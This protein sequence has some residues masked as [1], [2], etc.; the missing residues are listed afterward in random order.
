MHT[1][2][3]G[4]RLCVT[5]CPLQDCI[6]SGRE[7]S[8]REVFLK[9]KDGE[10]LAVYVKTAVFDIEGR[11]Y[12]VE[13]FG[14]LES[15]AGKE[16]AGRIQE[17]S[18]SAVS[19]PL[20][21]LFNRRYLDAAL[22]QQFAMFRR[23]GRRYGV[24]Q[25]DI[26]TL[27]TINDRLGHATGD[28]AIR[29]VAGILASN[30][31][32][33]DIAARFGG[34]EFVIICGLATEDDLAVYGRRLVR[35]V[36]DSRFAPAEDSGLR[37]TVSAGGSLVAVERRRRAGGAGTRRRRHV[38]GQ[39]PRPRRVRGDRRRRRAVTSGG[40]VLRRNPV[41]GKLTIVAPARASRPADASGRDVAAPPC[42][43]CAGN[44][45]LTPPEVDA[46]RPARRRA[47]RPRLDRARGPQQ[48]PRAG[49]PARGDRARARAR[50]GARG[51]S[52]RRTRRG[53]RHVAA[54][55]RRAARG[56]GRGRD[57]DRQPGGRLRGLAGAPARAAV[58]DA[59]GATAAARGAPRGRAVPQ[60]LRHLR[61]LRPARASR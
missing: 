31:R 53:R 61:G 8:I 44:E 28:E 45:A 12:G 6:D 27:K 7:H 58:R 41:S 35:V 60:P 1:D 26:D 25:M 11:R 23:L 43:F 37:L 29:F 34:D 33:M 3:T 13:I 21:G 57:A 38:R 36:H 24:I 50:G 48:V 30:A 20:T 17:L 19:D 22:A 39:A 40:G 47:G 59:G 52:G 15:V 16:L 9:R 55:R 14:E 5:G 4:T 49:G 42:P 46:L 2:L 10:R 32:D 54:A 51:P 56:R 18:D